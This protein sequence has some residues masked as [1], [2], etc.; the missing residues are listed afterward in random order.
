LL[1]GAAA[2]ALALN[3]PT[4]LVPVVAAILSLGYDMTQPL[5]GGIVTALGGRRAGQAMS[6][7]VFTLFVG[8]GLGSLGFGALLGFGF[9]TAFA[10]FASVELILGLLAFALFRSERPARASADVPPA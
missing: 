1:G 9:A 4:A 2:T 10:V 6:L 8:F 3:P 7:N 5:F